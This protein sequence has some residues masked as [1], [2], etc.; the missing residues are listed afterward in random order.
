MSIFFVGD[1]VIRLLFFLL[2]RVAKILLDRL[3]ILYLLIVTVVI[4]IRLKEFGI[5]INSLIYYH[6][7]L[8]LIELLVFR[9]FFH[10]F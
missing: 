3:L 10:C 7:P 8:E 1:F 9:E 5:T 2:V 6:F 4:C